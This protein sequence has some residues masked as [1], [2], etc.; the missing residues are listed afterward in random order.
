MCI[1][2][3]VASLHLPRSGP[4]I[5]TTVHL[6]FHNNHT[7][8]I[9]RSFNFANHSRPSL[10]SYQRLTPSS[11]LIWDVS[12][13]VSYTLSTSCSNF[14]LAHCGFGICPSVQQKR[15]KRIKN[16]KREKEE[17]EEVSRG[18]FYFVL[19]YILHVFFFCSAFSYS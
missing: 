8:T 12:R 6:H 3:L 1:L 11:V 19:R 9:S 5:L 2:Y 18:G 17:G 15:E 14:A 10:W 7:H 13:L 16:N 4:S